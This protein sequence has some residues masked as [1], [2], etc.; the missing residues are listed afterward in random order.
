[1]NY[2]K[3]LGVA[4]DASPED[5]KRAYR[6]LA[7][8]HHPDRGGDASKLQEINEAYSTLKDTNKRFN[9]DHQQNAPRSDFNVNTQNMDEAMFRQNFGDFN[10]VF[11]NMFSQGPR[12]HHPINKDITI[13]I[14]L[15]LDDIM[16]GK[17]VNVQ[18]KTTRGLEKAEIQIP[19]GIKDG[20]TIRYHG[21][22][23][24]AMPQSPRG[25]L[26]VVIKYAKH[27]YWT[28][29][30]PNLKATEKVHI[31]ELLKGTKLDI[32]TIG[33]NSLR[34][35]IPKGTA[36][37]TTFSIN[38]GGLP[39]NQRYSGNAYIKINAIMP[40]LTD[41]QIMEIENIIR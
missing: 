14:T 26:L 23:D 30:G 37:G 3:T 21:M 24:N 36:P 15:T 34:L 9:Y 1:M 31:L 18:Y 5:I 22:G 25:S 40:D 17:S 20:Q 27:R 13:S 28:V 38:G 39:V 2:Y 12:G 19:A 7:M 32:K 29:D 16:H 6:K 10:D 4:V 41:Q 11:N 35:N 33:G 8:Q